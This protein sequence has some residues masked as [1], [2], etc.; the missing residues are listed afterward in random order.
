MLTK[1]SLSIFLSKLS[2]FTSAKVK[3]EQYPTPSDVASDFMWQAY[4]NGHIQDKDV[5]DLGAGSG[6]LGIA[7]LLLGA[8][9][10]HF[11][12]C[13]LDVIQ[14]LKKNLSVLNDT[15]EYEGTYEIHHMPVAKFTTAV[16]CVIENPPFGTKIKH[17]D[18]EFLEQAFVIAPVVYSVHKTST[19][20]FIDAISRDFG[21]KV[22]QSFPYRYRLKNTM[23]FHQKSQ[24]YIE[25]SCYLLIR[26]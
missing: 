10:V 15:Y 12:E 26:N 13:D 7:A 14:I 2:V 18:K 23:S 20:S 4:M 6:I 16:D 21:Y 5:A 8:K 19:R 3:L 17:A 9:M 24:T 1:N 22:Q 11:V 25:V